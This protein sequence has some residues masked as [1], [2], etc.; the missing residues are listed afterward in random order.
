M[1]L[2]QRAGFT[3][4]QL[5]DAD[6][7]LTTHEHVEGSEDGVERAENQQPVED[8]KDCQQ[9]EVGLLKLH[10]PEEVGKPQA[11]GEID[12]E[13]AAEKYRPA[14][15]DAETTEESR[16]RIAGRQVGVIH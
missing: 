4:G 7:A 12:K 15:D 5:A 11:G 3:F 1:A 2:D 8:D 6:R 10:P 14:R 16:D 13:H 9:R